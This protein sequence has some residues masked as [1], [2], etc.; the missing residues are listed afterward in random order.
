LTKTQVGTCLCGAVEISIPASSI[1]PS[2]CHCGICRKLSGGG[3]FIALHG[4]E[5][6]NAK[7]AQYIKRYKSSDWAERCFCGEC[8]TNLF[9]HLT[10]G[11]G[12]HFYSAGL[13]QESDQDFT[14]VE[15]IFIDKKP[16][17]YGFLDKSTKRRTGAQV[18]EDISS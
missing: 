14:L 17:Y 3:P 8:G 10:E 7:G 12:E 6:L 5:T 11:S 15:E 18:F 13:F 2:A 16:D 4:D 1:K 9:Y